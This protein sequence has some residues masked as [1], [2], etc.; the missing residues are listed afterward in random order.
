VDDAADMRD[1]E[2]A[3]HIEPDARDL[4]GGETP[5]A[6]KPGGEVLSFDERHDQVGLV[7]VGAGI[8]AGDDV[9]MT[10][11]GRGEGFASESMGKVAIG[12][13][14]GSQDLDRD[15]VFGSDVDRPVDRRHPTA[16]DERPEPVA[17]TEEAIGGRRPGQPGRVGRHGHAAKIAETARGGP[18]RCLR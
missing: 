10:Q 6:P 18:P 1:A 8:E 17:T 12:G 5:A 7:A 14:F 16:P 13:D 11:Y 15:L 9:R 2:A 4:P 3:R